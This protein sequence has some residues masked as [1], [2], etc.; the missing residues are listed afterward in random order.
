VTPA[1]LS[2]NAAMTEPDPIQPSDPA[3]PHRPL[4]ARA[5]QVVVLVLALA[6]VAGVAWRGISYWRVGTEPLEVAPPAAGPTYRVN[7]NAADW[8]VLA[9]VPGLGET[10]SRRIVEARQAR[11][12]RFQSLDDLKEVRGIGDKTLDRV[13]PYLFVGEPQGGT[14]PVVMTD[15]PPAR[16][17][18]G[19]PSARR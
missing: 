2:H 9:L 19:E 3:P 15:E 6:V 4:V 10:L 17:P 5:E 11:G 14:E 16:R 7:V 1:G 13:R 8:V 12:G 18:G